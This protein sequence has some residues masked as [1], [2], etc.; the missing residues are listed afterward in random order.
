MLRRPAAIFV[1][2]QTEST[3]GSELLESFEPA[4]LVVRRQSWNAV[5]F[6]MFWMIAGDRRECTRSE[7]CVPGS[8]QGAKS[9][10]RALYFLV[11]A[12]VATHIKFDLINFLTVA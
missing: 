10:A 8:D 2:W 5:L 9:I 1:G 3:F 12:V 11:N 4:I 6:V 7:H